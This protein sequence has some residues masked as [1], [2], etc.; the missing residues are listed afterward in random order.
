M[1]GNMLDAVLPAFGGL[2]KA[3]YLGMKTA[4]DFEGEFKIAHTW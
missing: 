1:T 2:L 4:Q 3:S